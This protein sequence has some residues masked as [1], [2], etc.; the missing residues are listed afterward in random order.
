[1]T[2]LVLNNWTQFNW[3][4]ASQWHGSWTFFFFFSDK[5]EIY[6]PVQFMDLC[7]FCLYIFRLFPFCLLF[8]QIFPFGL[9]THSHFVYLGYFKSM[10]P[11]QDNIGGINLY[12]I[13]CME[14][15]QSGKA[16]NVD[17]DETFRRWSGSTFLV[18]LFPLISVLIHFVWKTWQTGKSTNGG[19]LGGAKVS[20]IFCHPG[21]PADIGW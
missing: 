21:C 2:S 13:I 11:T 10:Q 4:A 7:P 12:Y 9:L 5:T 18:Y 8:W 19:W 3:Y 16:T 20:C 1:M 6:K 17:P 15:L 14:K